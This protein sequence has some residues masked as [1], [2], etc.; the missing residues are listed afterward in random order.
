MM[1]DRS[2]VMDAVLFYF[3]VV[4]IAAFIMY[5]IDKARARNRRWRVSERALLLPAV[6]GGAWGSAAGM[7]VFRHKTRH[8][9][10]R[11]V[12]AVSLIVYMA[13]ITFLL[14]RIFGI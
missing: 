13:V 1:S 2:L 3:L 10:F 6:L 14:A 4:N 7:L 12:V 8:R 11:V 9:R 5:G